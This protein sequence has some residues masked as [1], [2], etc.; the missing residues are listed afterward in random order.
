MADK[1]NAHNIAKSSGMTLK[2]L[3]RRVGES[4]QRIPGAGAPGEPAALPPPDEFDEALKDAKRVDALTIRR[5]SQRQM[6]M[7]QQVVEEET[8]GRL[9]EAQAR[10]VQAEAE[11]EK[12]KLE[13]EEMR[14]PKGGAANEMVL[15]YIEKLEGQ[16]EATREEMAQLRETGRQAEVAVLQEKLERVAGDLERMRSQSAAAPKERT[17]ADS[18][19]DLLETRQAFK[20]LE[21]EL[22]PPQPSLT[23]LPN[24]KG[25]VAAKI[26]L[27]RTEQEFKLKA[28]ELERRLDIEEEVARAE[29]E[30]KRAQV[31]QSKRRI[32]VVEQNLPSM[33]DYL[34][35]LAEAALAWM[36]NGGQRPPAAAELR[37]PYPQGAVA[38]GQ[39]FGPSPAPPTGGEPEAY[40]MNCGCGTTFL[41][42]AGQNKAIC[43]QCRTIYT[44]SEGPTPA[45]E[46]DHGP[47]P[48]PE[49]EE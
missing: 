41:V 27:V 36:Q 12:A 49:Y 16:L 38:A 25:D 9:K 44:A 18:M 7:E 35:P 31:E 37:Q 10:R 45:A 6:L 29:L 30:V 22:V 32:D 24:G 5:S 46:P 2:D 43:Q 34:K 42:V 33:F 39:S 20:A 15:H 23:A 26:A 28:R 40:P 14:R 48:Q 1:P 47:S 19:R 11:A 3:H 21:E 13:L 17:I 4:I 8:A